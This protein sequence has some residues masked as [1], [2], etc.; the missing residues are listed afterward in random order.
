M[1]GIS[2][3]KV[4][5]AY[6]HRRWRIIQRTAMP[7]G[8]HQR[9]CETCIRMESR[10]PRCKLAFRARDGGPA[11]KRGRTN[12]PTGVQSYQRLSKR[13]HGDQGA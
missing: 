3:L 8:V 2:M 7:L 10:A 4:S 5:C 11:R 13:R 1:I 12:D 9:L 6:S